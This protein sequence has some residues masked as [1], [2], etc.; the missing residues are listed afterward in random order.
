MPNRHRTR[1]SARV[2]QCWAEYLLAVVIFSACLLAV[3]WVFRVP[4]LQNPDETSHIDYAFS[5]YSAGR[6]LNVRTPPSE[7]NVHPQFGG[8]KDREG[9][10]STPYDLLSHQY[11]LYL[12]DATDFHRIRFHPNEKVPVDY[13]TSAYYRRV[14]D[15][16][17]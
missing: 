13:G 10:E 5:I 16:A 7:W 2:K 11:T 15:T 4:L 6:L 17:P 8:R 1:V 12:I 3:V 14:D 9:V